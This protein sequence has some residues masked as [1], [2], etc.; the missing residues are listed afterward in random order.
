MS[1]FRLKQVGNQ[2]ECRHASLPN[3]CTS[4]ATPDEAIKN[5]E[6]MIADFGRFKDHL[7]GRCDPATC[8]HCVTHADTRNIWG[9]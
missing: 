3:T 8:K 9:K 6:R 5:G 7:N 4:G 1:S 2:W